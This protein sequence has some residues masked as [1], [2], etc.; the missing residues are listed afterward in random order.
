M[1]SW[2]RCQWYLR[3]KRFSVQFKICGR[4][5]NVPTDF[6][7]K[8]HSLH[9]LL[10]VLGDQ[11]SQLHHIWGI[12]LPLKDISCI[13]LLCVCYTQWLVHV[14]S[15]VRPRPFASVGEHSCTNVSQFSFSVLS[16]HLPYSSKDFL[17]AFLNLQ[18]PNP[19]LRICFS[20]RTT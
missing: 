15:I 19:H 8:G 5:Y 13:S 16:T 6:R 7:R 4:C 14:G 9:Q 12:V 11:S 20:G 3:W 17:G 2:Q 10:A 18:C 1:I